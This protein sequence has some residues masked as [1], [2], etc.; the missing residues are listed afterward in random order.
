MRIRIRVK[1]EELSPKTR[2]ELF[3]RA[4]GKCEC[5]MTICKH[6]P[7][8]GPCPNKLNHSWHAHKRDR[9]KGYILSNIYA[10]CEQCHENTRT[11]GRP[12]SS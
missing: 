7:K 3:D 1:R 11:Y 10:L 4:G 12:L 6:H 9:S 8:G 2:Q 5:T